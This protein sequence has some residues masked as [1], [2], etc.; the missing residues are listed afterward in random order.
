MKDRDYGLDMARVVSMF[1]IL[2]LHIL[3]QGGLLLSNEPTSVRYWIYWGIEII[4]YSSVDVFAMLT[5]WLDTDQKIKSSVVRIVELLAIT[6]FYSIVITGAF[7]FF[8]PEKITGI[9]SIINGVFP[10]IVGRYWYIG[11]YIPVALLR[12]YLSQACSNITTQKHKKLCIILV[13]VF[14]V[15]PTFTTVDFFVAKWGYSTIWLVICYIIGSYIKRIRDTIKLSLLELGGGLLAIVFL[16]LALKGVY[17]KVTGGNIPGIIEYTSPLILVN[18]V[19]VLLLFSKLKIKKG[20]KVLLMFSNT[21]FDVY[22][23]HCHLFVFDY[24]IN[25][26]FVWIDKYPIVVILFVLLATAMVCY[27]ALS[28]VGIIRSSLFKRLKCD[29][30]FRF[31]SCKLDKIIY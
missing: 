4:A 8:M 3:G 28:F 22:I 29:K 14:S 10:M 26:N 24:I 30:I 11:C 31:L 1:G 19:I 9:K 20:K 25:G 27:F 18:A 17:W 2:M 13:G 23:V 6:V 16:L 12:P 21:A 15:I 7:M 5:G